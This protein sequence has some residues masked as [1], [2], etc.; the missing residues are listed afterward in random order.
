MKLIGVFRFITDIYSYGFKILFI[1][2][3]LS[4][5]QLC[6][7]FQVVCYGLS[8]P[9]AEHDI[10]KDC[11]SIYCEW[12]SCLAPVPKISV[13]KPVAERPDFY[14]RKMIN[15]LYHLF[16]PRKGEGIDSLML[17]LLIIFEVNIQH[18][19]FFSTSVKLDFVWYS[20]Y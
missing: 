14:A 16:T 19:L 17:K 15:Q 5:V 6:L 11:V 4:F 10:I 12:L 9:F 13:P 7:W 20:S 1:Y 18:K 8:L 2:E 3:L